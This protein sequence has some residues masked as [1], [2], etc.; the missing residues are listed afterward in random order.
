MKGKEG[1]G[2]GAGDDGGDTGALKGETLMDSLK[3]GE[4]KEVSGAGQTGKEAAR[5][6]T[7]R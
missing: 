4:K 1:L 7:V 5:A 3:D 6:G 2:E